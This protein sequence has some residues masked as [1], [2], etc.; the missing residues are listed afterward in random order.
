M[1]YSPVSDMIYDIDDIEWKLG[2]CRNDLKNL[3]RRLRIK[4]NFLK[5]IE[6]LKDGEYITFDKGKRYYYN[7][8]TGKDGRHLHTLVKDIE[9]TEDRKNKLMNL[10][11]FFEISQKEVK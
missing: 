8:S 6:A 9:K 10:K 1:R 3:E 11:S 4:N 5:Q 2:I 7:K